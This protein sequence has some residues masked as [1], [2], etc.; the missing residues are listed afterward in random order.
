MTSNADLKP[1]RHDKLVKK[2]SFDPAHLPA[3]QIM[4]SKSGAGHQSKITGSKLRDPFE[5]TLQGRM[6]Q[7]N[8][9]CNARG[10]Q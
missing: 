8:S 3:R 5:N 2:K 10:M 7:G 9:Q 4:S 6:S 1:S